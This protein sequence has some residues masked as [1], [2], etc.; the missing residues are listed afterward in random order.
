MP[1][2]WSKPGAGRS[3]A[4]S[5]CVGNVRGRAS[6]APACSPRVAARGSRA[7]WG[8]RSWTVHGLRRCSPRCAGERRHR[9]RAAMPC[10]CG[11]R[12]PRG[13]VV[14]KPSS[15]TLSPTV[16]MQCPVLQAEPAP[17]TGLPQAPTPGAQ[18]SGDRR[19]AGEPL[20]HARQIQRCRTAKTAC[21]IGRR[22]QCRLRGKRRSH[23]DRGTIE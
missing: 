7:C 18:A 4:A 5:P 12:V 11:E 15:L 16:S 23:P 2:R 21:F 1:G 9:P 13:V 14:A 8:R 3:A 20:G 17:T 22:R 19:R 6:L 10:Q